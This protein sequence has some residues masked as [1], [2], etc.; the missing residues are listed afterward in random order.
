MTIF[1]GD[2]A[3]R[4]MLK[5]DQWFRGFDK[6]ESRAVMFGKKMGQMGS[7]MTAIGK[8]L[9][10]AI[11]LPVLAIGGIATKQFM[12][13]EAAMRDVNTIARQSETQFQRTGRTVLDLAM[14]MGQQP[15]ELADALYNINSASFV[16]DRGLKVLRQSAIAGRAG[17]AST[18]E[19]A[20]ALTGVLNA[21]GKDV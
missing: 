9:S 8:R 15:T 12:D 3:S 14:E 6:A 7:R 2:I 16:A 10:L 17:V 18:A 4:L 21:Y 5:T 19:A 11:T 13:F 1:L 20:K